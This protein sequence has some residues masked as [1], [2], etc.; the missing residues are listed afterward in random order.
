MARQSSIDTVIAKIDADIAELQRM[1]AYLA[2]PRSD[3]APKPK[4]GRKPKA[5]RA[6]E[7]GI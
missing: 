5:A 6:P 1:R 4:R 2:Q 7:P 3:D